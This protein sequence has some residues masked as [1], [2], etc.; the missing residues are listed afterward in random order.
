MDKKKITAII[1]AG[2]TGKR[3]RLA[4]PK[5]LIKIGDR[6]LLFY[7][8]DAFEKS[9]FVDDIVFVAAR[10]FLKKAKGLIEK[11]KYKKISRIVSGGSTRA[12]SVYNGLCACKDSFYVLIHDAA[13]P[14]IAPSLI[15]KCADTVSKG[16]NCLLAV[17]VKATIKKINLKNRYVLNTPDRNSLWEAQTPQAFNRKQLLAAYEKLNVRAWRFNDDA[18]LAEAC[19]IKVKVIPGDYRNIKITTREDLKIAQAL[20]RR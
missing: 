19:G 12:R 3:M 20:A 10:Y 2:G 18:S 7:S 4:T 13:R 6:K 1:V 17:G 11:R 14:F 9:K 15:K 5:P 8:L 16:T